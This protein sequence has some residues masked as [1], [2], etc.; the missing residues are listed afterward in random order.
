MVSA[1]GIDHQNYAERV[2]GAGRTPVVGCPARECGGCPMVPHASYR[3][4][5]RG[6]LARVLRLRCPRCAVTHA[7][8]PEDVCAYRDA[9]LSSVE[10]TVEAG[11]RPVDGARAAGE[12]GSGAT[13][14][15]RRWQRGLG[16][17]LAS[18]IVALLP[19]VPG[20]WLERARRVVG[21]G[22]GVLVRLRHWLWAHHVLFFGGPAGLYRH[23]RPQNVVRRASTHLGSHAP[24]GTRDRPP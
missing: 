2:F 18:V 16:P 5:V 24:A 23:G 19:A 20:T 17:G 9:L 13:R 15:V 12:A 6:E 3:R 11:T 21:E 4:Y 10:V 14:R 8:L 1:A 22:D 7:L